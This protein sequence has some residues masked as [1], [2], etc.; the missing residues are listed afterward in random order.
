MHSE[1]CGTELFKE[2]SSDLDLSALTRSHVTCPADALP[3]SLVSLGALESW[4]CYGIRPVG[5]VLMSR[6]TKSFSDHR[7]LVRAS[8]SAFRILEPDQRDEHTVQHKASLFTGPGFAHPVVLSLPQNQASGVGMECNTKEACSDPEPVVRRFSYGTVGPI[9]GATTELLINS[10]RNGC[11][12]RPPRSCENQ[13]PCM[14]STP[15]WAR[16]C[17]WCDRRYSRKVER[18]RALRGG[19]EL[20]TIAYSL[21][22]HGQAPHFRRNCWL[23]FG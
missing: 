2:S 20:Y 18:E 5:W 21:C 4:T 3:S 12:Y 22:N 6:Y 7:P 9:I 19:N 8:G 17:S 1:L 16:L 13:D 11:E 23:W 10:M 14:S 15:G